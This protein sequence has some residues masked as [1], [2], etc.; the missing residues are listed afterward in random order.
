MKN[1]KFT[2]FADLKRKTQQ[3]IIIVCFLL[4][5][6][7]LLIVFNYLPLTQLLLYSFTDWNGIGAAV[8]VGFKNYINILSSGQFWSLLRNNLI[9]LLFIPFQVLIGVI[10]AVLIYD[11][12]PG[13][14]IFRVIYYIPQVISAVI[15]GYLFK[16]LFSYDGAV[17]SVLKALHLI[18]E[19]IPW[20]ERSGTAV[21]ICLV[22]VNIGWQCL[23][24]L[25]GLSS[26]SP[27]VYEAAR[28]DGAGYWTQLFRITFPLLGRTMEYSCITSVMWTFTGIFPYIYSMTG[29]GPG[30]DTTT[31]DYMV[32]LKS[33]SAN[34]QY[35]YA[36][37]LS[38]LL[39]IVI[40]ILTVVQLRISDRQNRWEG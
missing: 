20:L 36:S 17:N 29:G 11:G 33:F 34:S 19:A 27:A 13:G 3:R 38:V 15:V 14:K 21:I 35:G 16:V 5:P 10:V 22:W 7:T 6:T 18:R 9:F 40:M 1:F 32:Y 28:L 30:Y 2:R 25:G 12:I 37:A 24:A 26:I 8:S 4:F 39:I 23:L 31:L